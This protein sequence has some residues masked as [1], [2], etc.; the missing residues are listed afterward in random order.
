M[1][2][3]TSRRA[4]PLSPEDRRAAIVAAVVPLVE[5]YGAAVTTRQVAEAAGIAEGTIFRVFD[6]K[7][8]LLLATAREVVHPA[9]GRARLADRLAEVGDLR[10]AVLVSVESILGRLQR[11]MTVM[12]AVRPLLV[13]E[14]GA[15]HRPGPPGFIV[16]A[17]RDLLGALTDLVFAPYADQLRV[18]PDRAALVLRSLV[19]GTW[20]PGMPESGRLSVEEIADACL[21]GVTGPSGGGG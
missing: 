21:G 8:A 4:A 7:R 18:A 5:Q 13:P 11:A 16:E 1:P 20:H 9:D 19:F 2:T 12:V 10:S 17:N 15:Q 6:D 14:P 3:R